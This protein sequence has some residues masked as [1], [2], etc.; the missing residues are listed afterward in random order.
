MVDRPLSRA[1]RRR[2]RLGVGILMI[3]ALI[4]GGGLAWINRRAR[5]QPDA[6]AAPAFT[7][8]V[9][10]LTTES[11]YARNVERAA[12]V[13][14]DTIQ[15]GLSPDSQW[16]IR[17]FAIDHDIHTYKIGA[18]SDGSRIT[19]EEAAAHIAKHYTDITLKTVVLRIHDPTNKEEARRVLDEHGLAGVL[20]VGGNGATFY[21]P[22]KGDYRSKSRPR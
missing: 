19:P 12:T 10:I 6:I 4:L 5:V 8:V 2:L 18:R 13:T 9:C 15:F 21:N 7:L 1:W 22:D 3:L 11:S 20:E 14:P 16:R 17:T